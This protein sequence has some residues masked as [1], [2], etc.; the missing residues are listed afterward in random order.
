MFERYPF[1]FVFRDTFEISTSNELAGMTPKKFH[2]FP[3]SS[4]ANMSIVAVLARKLFEFMSAS[5]LLEDVQQTYLSLLLVLET[6]LQVGVKY[7]S[8]CS[9]AVKR[10]ERGP[11]FRWNDNSAMRCLIP[12][13]NLTDRSKTS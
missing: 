6:P 11:I 13:Q 7:S 1:L 4:S 8:K 9:Q 10:E 3:G 2:F 5:Y 12:H